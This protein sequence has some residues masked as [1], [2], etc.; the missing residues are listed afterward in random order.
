MKTTENTIDTAKIGNYIFTIYKRENPTRYPDYPFAVI[1]EKETPKGK[2]SKTKT[3]E[4]LVKKSYEDCENYVTNLYMRI[5][6]NIKSDEARKNE[7]KEAKKNLNAADFFAEGDIIYNSWGY[8]QTNIE[9]FQVVRITGK[10]IVVK[11]IGQEVEEGSYYSHGMAF[12]VLALKDKFL[13]YK[14][15]I[16]IMVRPGGGLTTPTKSH[17]CFSKWDGRPK[18]CSTYY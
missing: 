9:F 11:G 6:K 5:A 17:G 3:I 10:S 14:E 13:N 2:Y 15:E 4:H 18:Y 1:Y 8:E 12:N 16:K 7:L